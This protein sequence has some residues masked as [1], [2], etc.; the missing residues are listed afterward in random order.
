MEATNDC[1]RS[2]MLSFALSMAQAF[3]ELSAGSEHMHIRR[4]P[5]EAGPKLRENSSR[6]LAAIHDRAGRR[7]IEWK[8]NRFA[9]RPESP[10]H[11]PHPLI[12]RA[13]HMFF[14]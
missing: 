12:S 9:V 11:N 10:A 1:E 14:A 5:A 3:A 8:T 6:G 2:D 13:N 4:R 7:I